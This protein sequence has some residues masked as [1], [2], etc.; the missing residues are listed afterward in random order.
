MIRIVGGKTIPDFSNTITPTDNALW[1]NSMYQLT[2]YSDGTAALLQQRKS[3]NTTILD[4][5]SLGGMAILG[6]L[7]LGVI[8]NKTNVPDITSSWGGP[9]DYEDVNTGT[10]SVVESIL[11]AKDAIT[12]PITRPDTKST[13]APQAKPQ[14][15]VQLTASESLRRQLKNSEGLRLDAYKPVKKEKYYTIGYGHY[16]PDV[17][18]GQHI[19]KAQAEALF[20]KDLAKFESAV[21]KYVKVPITQNQFDALVSF[22]YN[23]GIGNFASSTLLKKLNRKDYLGAQKEFGRWVYGEGKKKLPGL[24]KRRA[25]EAQLFGKDIIATTNK[26]KISQAKKVVDNKVKPQSTK[27]SST[28]KPINKN[29]IIPGTSSRINRNWQR[30]KVPT[31]LYFIPKEWNIHRDKDPRYHNVRTSNY[32][33][34]K[35]GDWQ[36]YGYN[37]KGLQGK[38]DNKTISERNLVSFMSY[39]L[40]CEPNIFVTD[41]PYGNKDFVIRLKKFADEAKRLLGFTVKM[42]GGFGGQHQTPG[43]TTWGTA[44]DFQYPTRNTKQENQLNNIACKY[45]LFIWFHDAGKGYH[46]HIYLQEKSGYT[47]L[48]DTEQL[49]LATKNG[50]KINDTSTQ[51]AYTKDLPARTTNSIQPKVAKISQSSTGLQAKQLTPNIDLTTVFGPSKRCSFA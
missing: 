39:G 29:K 23:V 12:A 19:T 50:Q 40:Q 8:W 25:A 10:N 45:G 49:Q 33:G 3:L 31:N 16:G 1:N 36:R 48:N 17:K 47:A 2:R 5:V 18:A 44:A 13:I 4:I 22:A 34:Y 35:T 30:N 14:S 26:P 15:A 46:G 51:L 27:I 43:H 42:T 9:L 41:F 7:A 24:V 11:Q 20:T 21:R 6:A 28:A 32:A 37:N 38:P